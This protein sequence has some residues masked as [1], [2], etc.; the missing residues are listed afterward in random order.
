MTSKTNLPKTARDI[1]FTGSGNDEWSG[2]NLEN[3][4]TSPQAAL[5]KVSLI[6]P[7]PSQFFPASINASATGASFEGIVMPNSVSCNADLFAIITSDPIAQTLGSNQSSELGANVTTSSNAINTLVDGEQRVTSKDSTMTVGSNGGTPTTGNIGIK[8]TGACDNIFFERTVVNLQGDGA[9]GIDHTATSPTPVQYEIKSGELFNDN[10]TVFKMNSPVGEQVELE[11]GTVR[12][13]PSAS[14]MSSCI[15][16]CISGAATAKGGSLVAADILR[17]G[18]DGLAI[19]DVLGAAGDVLVDGTA[20]VNAGFLIGDIDVSAGALLS[21]ECR[22]YVGDITNSGTM[23][24]DYG[25]IRGDIT[26][27][28]GAVLEIVC[29]NHVG[30]L[31]NNGTING[32][33]NGVRFGNWIVAAEDVTYDN[34][35]SELI[36]DNVQD[37]IDELATPEIGIMFMTENTVETDINAVG[38]GVYTDIAGTITA[39]ANNNL[40]DFDGDDTLTYTGERSFEAAFDVSIFTKRASAAAARVMKAALLINDVVVQEVPFTMTASI[41]NASFVSAG[42]LEMDDEIKMQVQNTEDSANIVFTTFDF[43]ILR[44]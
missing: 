11:M 28:T 16:H 15:I 3:A 18:V 29:L 30:N 20:V 14:T 35:D 32:I 37:A 39:G 41:T 43:R 24:I 8:V 1:V 42:P 19:L 31:T 36:A 23:N 21:G 22:I 38:V 27:E 5:V 34:T 33:I 25:S 12:I 10:Q 9:I 2:V 17:V 6:T 26:V 4:V 40:F 44:A 13:S 7:P